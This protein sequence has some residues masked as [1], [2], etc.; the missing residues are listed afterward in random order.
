MPSG[1]IYVEEIAFL[2]QT[3]SPC[4]VWFADELLGYWMGLQF[5]GRHCSRLCALEVRGSTLATGGGTYCVKISSMDLQPVHSSLVEKKKKDFI[6]APSINVTR[7]IFHNCKYL[8]LYDS[9][10][11]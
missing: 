8:C 6:V 4:V 2:S 10:L 1:S 11:T 7:P 5:G 3:H 9:I